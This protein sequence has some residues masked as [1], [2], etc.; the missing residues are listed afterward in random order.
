MARST[1]W[2]LNCRMQD[3]DSTVLAWLI[4][5]YYAFRQQGDPEPSA[6]MLLANVQAQREQDP[7]AHWLDNEGRQY[8]G[9]TAKE[10]ATIAN[11]DLEAELSRELTPE[12]MGRA[13]KRCGWKQDRGNGKS[14][15]WSP[16]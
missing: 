7:I 16:S 4:R 5:G 15:T 1:S 9:Q 13:L 8:A 12:R 10:L 11:I 6:A 14:R 2:T 3:S